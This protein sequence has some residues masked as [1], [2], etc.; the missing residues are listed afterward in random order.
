MSSLINKCAQRHF[1]QVLTI[2]QVVQCRWGKVRWELPFDG[3]QGENG[4]VYLNPEKP[5]S[6]LY[7]MIFSALNL[8]EDEAYAVE[9]IYHGLLVER[10]RGCN[11]PTFSTLP[12]GFDDP[13]HADV[14]INFAYLEWKYITRHIPIED[15]IC[16]FR[17][18]REARL[19]E[20]GEF[21]QV[22]AEYNQQLGAHEVCH[23][24]Y[25]PL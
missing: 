7:Q 16:E 6:Q 22:P 5:F 25:H 9:V 10:P 13:P 18:I 21:L 1:K 17:N 2:V 12:D 24:S 8:N 19:F 23:H 20:E 11:S 15:W 14:A 3:N 4:V